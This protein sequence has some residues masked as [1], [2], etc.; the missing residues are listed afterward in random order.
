MLLTLEKFQMSHC[1][2]HLTAESFNT[3]LGNVYENVCK[4]E[5]HILWVNMSVVAHSGGVLLS[6]WTLTCCT[7]LRMAFIWGLNS[8]YNSMCGT[9]P[10]PLNLLFPPPKPPAIL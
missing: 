9:I 10:A 2:S 1:L 4:I 7:Y 5:C 6:F 8:N 3:H